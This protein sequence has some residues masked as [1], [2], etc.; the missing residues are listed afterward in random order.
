VIQG[1]ICYYPEKLE[2]L[3]PIEVGLE[4]FLGVPIYDSQGT[5]LGHLAVRDDQRLHVNQSEIDVLKI[6]AARAGIELERRRAESERLESERQLRALNERLVDSNR[7]LEAMVAARTHEIER[8]RQVAESLREMVLILNSERPLA[9]ILDYIVATA[10][11][12][13]GTESSAIFT[14]QA[15]GETLAIQ[16]PHGLPPGY[17]TQ[18]RLPVKR[19][20]LGRAILNRQPVVISN[21][22]S[23][24]LEHETTLDAYRQVLLT[25]QYQT[26]LA[27][28]LTG[29]NRQRLDAE[30]YGGIAL[31]YPE[32]RQF[33]DE[34]IELAVAFGAQAALAIENAQLRQQA[35]MGAILAERA[36][37]ARELH[38]SVTQQLYS[39]TL[40][41][42]GWR[43]MARNGRLIQ[44]E[45][46]LAELGQLGQQ[47]LK[48]MRLL[49]HEL[50]PPALEEDGLLGALYQRLAAVERRAG[51]EARLIATDAL[52]VPAPLEAGLYRIAQEA[53]NNTLKHAAATAV[54]IYLRTDQEAII[55]EVVDNGR[56][57]DQRQGEGD[58]GLGLASMR[59]RARHLGGALTVCSA[60]GKGTTVQ[61][62]IP[63]GESDRV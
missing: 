14:L 30:V 7:S 60:P 4:S 37:L 52:E 20:L 36:R 33:S 59:E 28:P 54:T 6:F 43:R 26:L 41:A 44:V 10:S 5:I 18:L 17:A 8:R 42:E 32:Q 61:V 27:V 39:L 40:L 16:T 11:S 46:A 47:A 38:D 56:G 48:E 24:L 9:E 49:I 51:V 45:E 50:R 13:L 2:E 15:D 21:L 62:V 12:L 35:E 29:Q 63:K 23:A 25:T 31:Y 19:S 55:L 57:F 22:A 3:F 58:G 53:L 1:A 34:E